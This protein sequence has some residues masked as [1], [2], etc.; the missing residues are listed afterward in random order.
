MITFTWILM[1]LAATLSWAAILGALGYFVIFPA[2]VRAGYRKAGLRFD[3][4][5]LQGGEEASGSEDAVYFAARFD[6]RKAITRIAGPAP[7]AVYWMIGIY[8]DRLQ[9]IPGGHL[10]G[11][12]AEIDKDGQF[13]IAIQSLP[14]NASS[15]LECG[16]HR[17][18]LLL[19][20]VFLPKD[21]DKVVAPTIQRMPA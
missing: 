20:R 19:M 15:T 2:I 8:D 17:I 3:R 16:R 10:N 6:C 12:T 1:R 4:F 9:R 11:A 7:D 21:K 5:Q 14:G 18:G 13:Q